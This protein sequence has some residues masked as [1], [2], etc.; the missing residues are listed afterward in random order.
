MALLCL[1]A[2][3]GLLF[4]WGK[5][6]PNSPPSDMCQDRKEAGRGGGGVSVEEWAG[7]L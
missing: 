7:L 2:L 6:Q 1:L 4:W 3:V 5:P